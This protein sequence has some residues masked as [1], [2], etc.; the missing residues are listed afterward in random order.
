MR[1][2]AM[3]SA[4]FLRMSISLSLVHFDH[5]CSVS[6]DEAWIP[7]HESDSMRPPVW[8]ALVFFT[9]TL[10]YIWLECT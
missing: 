6:Q 5:S 2:D 9:D 4:Y 1:N 3:L 10:R 8:T 7:L